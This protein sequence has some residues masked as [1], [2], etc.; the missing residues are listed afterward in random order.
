MP[1]LGR[2]SPSTLPL[3]PAWTLSLPGLPVKPAKHQSALEI[4]C[5]WKPAAEPQQHIS[6][7]TKGGQATREGPLQAVL[8]T[9]WSNYGH[10]PCLSLGTEANRGPFACNS[11]A[12][13]YYYPPS[14]PER[15]CV[16]MRYSSIS[17][18]TWWKLSTWPGAVVRT[19]FKAG[20]Q[21]LQFAPLT[22]WP[23]NKF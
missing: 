1:K 21:K 20:G 4:L 10:H 11:S 3:S 2:L 12:D 8:K 14:L 23:E 5:L 16:P 6:S 22:T 7:R 19:G 15:V 13:I 9:G 18:F 17:Q